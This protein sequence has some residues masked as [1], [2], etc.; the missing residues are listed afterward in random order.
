MHLVCLGVM[1]RMLLLLI[2]GPLT[3]RIGTQMTEQISLHLVNLSNHIPS[4]FARKPRSDI[5][6]WK[7][8]ELRQFLLY[9]GIS[10]L[11]NTLH[12][13]MYNFFLCFQLE[14]IYF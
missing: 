14:S 6:R 7:A 2:K 8:T 11:K 1:K 4:D 12:I 3:C 13:N 5:Y 9:T 10:V